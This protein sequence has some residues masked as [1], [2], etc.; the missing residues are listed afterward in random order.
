P[1]PLAPMRRLWASRAGSEA[2]SRI[3]ADSAPRQRLRRRKGPMDKMRTFARAAAMLAATAILVAACGGDSGNGG[4]A[5]VFHVMVVNATDA[6]V[7]ISYTGEE[8]AD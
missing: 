6:D 4:V 2:E 3:L 1:G 7:T 8:P 5:G